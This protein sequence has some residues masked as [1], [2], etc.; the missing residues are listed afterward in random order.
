MPQEED[1]ELRTVGQ[2]SS[3]VKKKPLRKELRYGRKDFVAQM[4]SGYL[5]G[6]VL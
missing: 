1:V 6:K 2:N 4:E 3:N 5:K